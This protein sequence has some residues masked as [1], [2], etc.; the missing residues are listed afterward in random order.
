[1][2]PY[3][4]RL[5]V[6]SLFDQTRAKRVRDQC[7]IVNSCSAFSFSL[8]HT[9]SHSRICITEDL[10][11]NINNMFPCSFRLSVKSLCDQTRMK[12]VGDQCFVAISCSAFSFSL[13]H[14]HSHSRIRITEDLRINI[15][16]MFPY[17]FRWSVKS[18]CD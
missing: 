14:T 3:S 9:Y 7:F 6:R 13:R 11:I 5:S 16:N 4:F 18:L 2:F 17:S 8:R 12:H 1:M 15:N 10:R